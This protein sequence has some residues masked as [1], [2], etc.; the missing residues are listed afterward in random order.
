MN[1]SLANLQNPKRSVARE[2]LATQPQGLSVDG[3]PC[4]PQSGCLGNLVEPFALIHERGIRDYAA[5]Y[6]MD[7]PTTEILVRNAATIVEAQCAGEMK[8]GKWR[9]QS[10][11]QRDF[12]ALMDPGRTISDEDVV[13]AVAKQFS[14]VLRLKPTEEQTSRY[15]KLFENCAKDGDRREALQTVLQAVLLQTAANY[16]SESG[17]GEAD[18]SGRR[19]LSPRELAEALSL[20][21]NDDWVREFFGAADKGSWKRPNRSRPSFAMF[22]ITAI[23]AQ[24]CSDSSASTSTMPVLRKSSRIICLDSKN[25]RTISRKCVAGFAQGAG[26]SRFKAHAG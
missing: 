24:G 17:D 6:S 26:V 10:G 19:R 12:V 13:A 15:L 14:L 22:L 18:A 11:S 3:R 25:E 2:N 1:C 9:G 7:Q 5:L 20:A 16:R 8:D 23:A 21:L 4:F